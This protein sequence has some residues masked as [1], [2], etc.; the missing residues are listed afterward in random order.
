[1][2]KSDPPQSFYEANGFKHVRDAAYSSSKT[3]VLHAKANCLL[4][5]LDCALED[6]DA[7]LQDD[8]SRSLAKQILLA[9]ESLRKNTTSDENI[10]QWLRKQYAVMSTAPRACLHVSNVADLFWRGALWTKVVPASCRA[11][12]EE[13]WAMFFSALETFASEYTDMV[14]VIDLSGKKEANSDSARAE[15]FK[16]QL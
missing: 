1:M 16:M 3:D 2:L 6:W 14:F 10:L 4:N 5:I 9:A 13:K 11:E 7:L 12:E 15:H 8:V